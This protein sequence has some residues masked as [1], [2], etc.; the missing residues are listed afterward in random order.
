MALGELLRRS[1]GSHCSPQVRR[2]DTTTGRSPEH[3]QQQ[4][5]RQGQAPQGLLREHLLRQQHAHLHQ[6][7]TGFPRQHGHGAGMPI[8]AQHLPRQVPQTASSL[9]TTFFTHSRTQADSLIVDAA[10]RPVHRGA[11]S[12]PSQ[13]LNLSRSYSDPQAALAAR[14]HSRRQS[15]FVAAPKGLSNGAASTGPLLPSQPG[16][17][18]KRRRLSFA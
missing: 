12:V 16:G 1:Q 14:V 17:S 13:P 5:Q 9:P 4:Q 7:N 6:H 11:G 8:A 2:C 10:T 18:S 3:Q 15:L